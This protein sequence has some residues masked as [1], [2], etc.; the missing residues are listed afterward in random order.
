MI[1]GPVQYRLSCQLPFRHNARA[2][3]L[4]QWDVWFAARWRE[5]P[6]VAQC[7]AEPPPEQQ[8][9]T[10]E[11]AGGLGFGMTQS[12]VSPMCPVS[13]VTHVVRMDPDLLATPA[14]FEPATFSLE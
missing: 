13:T 6:R 10:S 4:L 8:T 7:L 2:R 9:V 11:L 1:Y 5:R 3:A 14:G 12:K